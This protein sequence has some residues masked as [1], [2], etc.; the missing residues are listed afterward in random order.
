MGG[1]TILFVVVTFHPEKK[2]LAALRKVLDGWPTLV[3]D[4][5]SKN[6]GY[7]GGANVG[8]RGAFR[9]GADWVVILNQDVAMT[10]KAVHELC[11]KL[12]QL[13][14]GIAGPF[15]GT[16]DPERWTTILPAR[17]KTVDYI[18][19]ACM[20]IHKDIT[21]RVG[22][23]YEPFFMYYE[24]ADLSVRAGQHGFPL[25]HLSVTGITHIDHPVWGKGS[26]RHEWFLSRNHLLFVLRLAPWRVKLHELVR[27]PKTVIEYLEKRKC[28][29]T[30]PP[31]G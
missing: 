4:N 3:I 13:P 10:K 30:T 9:K 18:S 27:L 5:S 24:D 16:L 8:M 2:A 29:D 14:P 21:E 12:K 11:A 15:A 23:F 7:G 28:A 25:V 19:G 22:Y 26:K 20:A 17:G 1:V 31:S 6:I